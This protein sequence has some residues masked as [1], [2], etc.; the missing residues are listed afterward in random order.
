MW[1]NAARERERRKPTK[2]QLDYARWLIQKT[3]SDPDWYA[4]ETMTRRQAQDA[5][6]RLS[7]DVDVSEWEG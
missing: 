5:I 1:D 4:L 6:D 2:A 3:K 7:V